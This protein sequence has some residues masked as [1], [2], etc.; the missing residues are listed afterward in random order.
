MKI[1]ALVVLLS[2]FAASVSVGQD[3]VFLKS[4]NVLSGRI[5][6]YLKNHIILITKS[7]E[8]KVLKKDIER[9][10]MGRVDVKQTAEFDRVELRD[11]RVVKGNV[12]NSIDGKSIIVAVP[13]GAE[14]I[15][16][17]E[18]VLE[19]IPRG[20]TFGKRPAGPEE[21]KVELKKWVEKLGYGGEDTETARKWLLS[22]GIFAVE[23]LKEKE[24][25]AT[26]AVRAEIRKI[27]RVNTMREIIGTTLDEEF[28]EI[29]K[30]LESPKAEKRIEALKGALLV[31][32]EEAIELVVFLLEDP[33]ESEEVRSFCV[34]LL[35]RM[36]R[37]RELISVYNRAD[38]SLGLALAVALGRNDIYLGIPRLIAALREEERNL[39]VFVG[40]HLKKY[41]GEDFIPSS[42]APLSQW[43][44]AA[45]QYKEW[46]DANKEK[47]LEKT[48]TF[49][50]ADYTQ[51]P[52]RMK[53]MRYWIRADDAWKQ[54]EYQVAEKNLREALAVDPTYAR[55]AL[56]L[57]IILFR[58]LQKNLEARSLFLKLAQGRYPDSNSFIYAQSM[59]YLG[60]VERL[61][62][63]WNGAVSWLFRA[64][65]EKEFFVKAY[66][67]L[68]E[69][70]YLWAVSADA[71]LSPEK[72]KQLLVQADSVYQ[73]G[74]KVLEKAQEELVPVPVSYVSLAEDTP[75]NRRDYMLGLK[76]LKA[77][78]VEWKK[79]LL[80]R[81]TKV[82]LTI[83]DLSQAE[84]RARETV[85]VDVNDPESHLLMAIVF[86]KK[87][88]RKQAAREYRFVLRI[89]PDNRLARQGQ[90][91][92]G[93]ITDK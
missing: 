46:W 10:R 43:E 55:A 4:G 35:R 22:R 85:R 6:D 79:K 64:T 2:L 54:G 21:L 42:D 27:L 89:D 18:L 41:T 88:D 58:N 28:P 60:L 72:R 36:N 48:R 23:Y 81:S 9:I 56:S 59:Y 3:Q 24:K 82:C 26:D 91:R 52:Q 45:D 50:A 11:G 78:L 1:N 75:F 65:Q 19:I 86:E 84:K 90:K 33:N 93:G 12:R 70:Y 37:Y 57:G 87:G 34:E 20:A 66:I 68:G 40:E 8:D 74:L 49:V 13:G 15:Y 63:N 7:G 14:A 67:E 5:E 32:P 31:Q 44:K 71:S 38:G 69:T 92:L 62:R 51:T 76:K 73:R 80:R 17:K 83:G 30:A 53:A 47:I 25:S 29:Y 16:P 77:G 61:F 39:R